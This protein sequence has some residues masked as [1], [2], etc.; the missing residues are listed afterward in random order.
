MC[1]NTGERKIKKCG[2]LLGMDNNPWLDENSMANIISFTELVKQYR[3]TYNTEIKDS[4]Y[5]H[6]QTGIVEFGRT[7]EG[8]YNISL[9]DGYKSDV[10]IENKKVRLDIH[11]LQQ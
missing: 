6:T 8:L 5:C 2:I 3:V 1:T 7:E 11:M 9:P 4:F 10:L